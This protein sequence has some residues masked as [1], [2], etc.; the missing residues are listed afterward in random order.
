MVT[1]KSYIE[2][3]KSCGRVGTVEVVFLLHE[4]ACNLKL[5]GIVEELGE[6]FHQI[7]HFS[8]V[9][10][11]V[12]YI[13]L[14]LVCAMVIWK[15][16][17]EGRKSCGRVGTVEVVFLLHATACNL[18]LVGIVEELSEDFHQIKHF[19]LVFRPVFYISLLFACCRVT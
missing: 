12:F 11:P 13:S 4:T 14:L 9:F 17:T 5:V 8:L 3:W 6:D 7:N 18:K 10:R 15:S 16:C 1:W 19:S 2:G